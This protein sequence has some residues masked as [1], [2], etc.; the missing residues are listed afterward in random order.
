MDEELNDLKFGA[1]LTSKE[2]EQ[3][4][5]CCKELMDVST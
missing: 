2:E 1:S 4:T 3:F 5:H